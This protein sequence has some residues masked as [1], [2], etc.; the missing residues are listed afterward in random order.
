MKGSQGFIFTLPYYRLSSIIE[1]LLSG[2]NKN[3]IPDL[4][5]SLNI[6]DYLSHFLSNLKV[7]PLI[8]KQLWFRCAVKVSLDIIK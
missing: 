2:E 7:R 1:S 8:Q 4:F 5:T 3:P 6:K